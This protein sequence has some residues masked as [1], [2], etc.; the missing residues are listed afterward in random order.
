MRDNFELLVRGCFWRNTERYH[1]FI[2]C[3]P[4]DRLVNNQPDCC[5][6]EVVKHLWPPLYIRSESAYGYGTDLRWN[7]VVNL[8]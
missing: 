4:G 7:M 5:F 3:V 6:S 8:I 1:C 2:Y